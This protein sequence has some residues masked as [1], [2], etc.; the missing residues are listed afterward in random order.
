MACRGKKENREKRRREKESGW[1]I[2]DPPPCHHYDPST[3]GVDAQRGRKGWE[4]SPIEREKTEL[5]FIYHLR[6]RKEQR[7]RGKKKGPIP[8]FFH[9]PP[10]KRKRE[11]RR[12]KCELENLIFVAC[13]LRGK[14]IK[15]EEGKGGD[16][17]G[18]PPSA[19]YFLLSQFSFPSFAVPAR[20]EEEGGRNDSQRE[21]EEG[22]MNAARPVLL[23]Q[24]PAERRLAGKENSAKEKRSRPDCLPA[25]LAREA[26]REKLARRGK[27]GRE[28]AALG[29]SFL[30]FL[31]DRRPREGG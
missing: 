7:K 3:P 31:G 11:E 12:E 28:R 4:Q 27:G 24:L 29:E 19:P 13:H 22:E 17:P 9:A 2:P 14:D 10:E 21:V 20:R 16:K 18:F 8:H 26:G 15:K 6:L 1:P 25:P 5:S 23:S 30:S